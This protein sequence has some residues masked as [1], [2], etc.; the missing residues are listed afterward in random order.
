MTEPQYLEML[1]SA[2]KKLRELAK[3]SEE[4]QLEAAKVRQFINATANMLPD[5][6]RS[7]IQTLLGLA[8]LDEGLRRAG[9]HDAIR[10]VLERHPKE[11]LTVARV[12]DDLRHTFD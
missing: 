5:N 4:I 2:V 10:Q 9:L 8:E 7:N 12:R 1:I 6:E 3:Q 11:F